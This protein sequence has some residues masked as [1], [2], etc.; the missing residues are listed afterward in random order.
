MTEP[1]QLDVA[2]DGR[3]LAVISLTVIATGAVLMLATRAEP[4]ARRV[5]AAAKPPAAASTPDPAVDSAPTPRPS[6]R[7][8]AADD[9]GAKRAARRFLAGYLAYSYGRRD[10]H[11]LPATTPAL[12]RRLAEQP[13]RVRRRDRRRRARIELLQTEAIAAQHVS[14]LALVNDRARRYCVQLAL[15]PRAERW[16]VT[17]VGA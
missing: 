8:T 10:A 17:N 9:R 7:G 6:R 16:L 5:A 11:T 4:P 1:D 13:P 3:R 15:E 2:A 12:R 14:L